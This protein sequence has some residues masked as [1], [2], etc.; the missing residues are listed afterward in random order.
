MDL[1]GYHDDQVFTPTAQARL[2]R[3][4]LRERVRNETPLALAFVLGR[5]F[6]ASA[7]IGATTVQQLCLDL[8]GIFLQLDP[9]ILRRIDD[10]HI[11][12]PNPAVDLA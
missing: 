9:H 2:A 12:R 10:S 4:L 6:V 1:P 8:A 7:V 3:I 11:D 5:P